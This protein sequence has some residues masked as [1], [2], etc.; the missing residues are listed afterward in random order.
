MRDELLF[1]Q[2]LDDFADKPLM[3]LAIGG[4]ARDE[5]VDVTRVCFAASV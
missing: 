4:V 2:R 5:N 3:R 1:G